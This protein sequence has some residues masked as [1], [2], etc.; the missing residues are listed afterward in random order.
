MESMKELLNWTRKTVQKYDINVILTKS[1]VDSYS[2]RP[3][4]SEVEYNRNMQFK[5]LKIRNIKSNN[6]SNIIEV[7]K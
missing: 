2:K 5:T 6:T 3:L 1:N 7:M 4:I